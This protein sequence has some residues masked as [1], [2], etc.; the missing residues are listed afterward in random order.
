MRSNTFSSAVVRAPVHHFVSCSSGPHPQ[1]CLHDPPF[2]RPSQVKKRTLIDAT[3]VDLVKD[4][5]EHERVEHDRAVDLAVD[6]GLRSVAFD[7][8]QVEDGRAQVQENEVDRDLDQAG[9]AVK[10][11]RRAR[12]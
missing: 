4:L 2:P 11:K 12:V 5:H 8:L 9:T 7:G 1:P 6:L 10:G 3:A